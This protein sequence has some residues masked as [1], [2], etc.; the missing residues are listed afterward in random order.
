MEISVQQMKLRQNAEFLSRLEYLMVTYAV[1]VLAEALA[2][3][4]HTERSNYAKKVIAFTSEY[5]QRAST[6]IVSGIN[7]ISTTVHTPATGETQESTV[8]TAT[9]AQFLSQVATLWNALAGIE[10]GE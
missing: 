6:M 3:S 10:T 4:N 8:T 2:T 9:D 5:A 7:I 1:T